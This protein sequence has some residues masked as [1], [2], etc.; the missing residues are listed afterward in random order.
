MPLENYRL[1]RIY[2]LKWGGDFGFINDNINKAEYYF[3]KSSVINTSIVS[4]S[5]LFECVIYQLENS[6]K[7][8]GKF[9]AK[10]I[11]LVKQL[12]DVYL[13]TNILFTHFL[14]K[15]FPEIRIFELQ[16]AFDECSF[17]KDNFHKAMIE[18]FEKL[19]LKET[20]HDNLGYRRNSTIANQSK[21]KPFFNLL[22]RVDINNYSEYLIRFKDI[23][24][25]LWY[26]RHIIA[27]GLNFKSDK[28]HIYD[29]IARDDFW[30]DIMEQGRG[31]PLDY[32][33][34]HEI[35]SRTRIEIYLQ[36]SN[37]KFKKDETRKKV[38]DL[39]KGYKKE[40]R[41]IDYCKMLF[42]DKKYEILNEFIFNSVPLQTRIKVYG[43]IGS[44]NEFIL[45]NKERV[46]MD[47][48]E[49]VRIKEKLEELKLSK[50]KNNF[51]NDHNSDEQESNDLDRDYFNTMTDGQ[52]GDW[53]DFKGDIDD[54]DTWARG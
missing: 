43:I 20:P 12:C 48:L 29:R 47:L 49:D 19:K 24:G 52:L 11:K 16:E 8:P 38:F 30:R 53:E 13:L 4:D 22:R 54:I 51:N 2:T 25:P 7:H 50:T 42:D 1:G 3:R 10:E 31:N 18:E 21:I 27:E 46:D 6:K 36:L 32:V 35:S 34:Y 28:E 33:F 45:A 5:I 44:E 39:F 15:Q 14:C 41:E 37:H 17:N 9:E 40:K 26:D 23:Y